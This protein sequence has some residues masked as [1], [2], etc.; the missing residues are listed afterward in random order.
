MQYS[1]LQWGVPESVTPDSVVEPFRLQLLK[2]VG[3]KQRVAH[4]IAAA[5]PAHGDYHEPFLGA[6]RRDGHACA[7]AGVRGGCACARD[8]HLT[9]AVARARGAESLVCHAVAAVSGW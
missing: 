5:F 1:L 2:W 9:G 8:R 4:R 3:S 6:G 7:G